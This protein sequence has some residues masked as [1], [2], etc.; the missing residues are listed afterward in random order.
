MLNSLLMLNLALD[1]LKEEEEEV[2]IHFF[3]FFFISKCNNVV[4]VSWKFNIL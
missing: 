3:L 1:S 2:G 4:I